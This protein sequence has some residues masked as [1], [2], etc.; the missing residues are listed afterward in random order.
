MFRAFNKKKTIE[1]EELKERDNTLSYGLKQYNKYIYDPNPMGHDTRQ[2]GLINQFTTH[3]YS[4]ITKLSKI[5]RDIINVLSTQD[6]DFNSFCFNAETTT[7]INTEGVIRNLNTCPAVFYF[8]KNENILHST[9]LFNVKEHDCVY[10]DSFC[11]NQIKRL[12]GG[13]DILEEFINIVRENGFKKIQLDAIITAVSFYEKLGFIVDNPSDT[14]DTIPMT[15]IIQ[16][17]GK[18]HK[19]KKKNKKI[20]KTF[21]KK[22]KKCRKYKIY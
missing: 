15:K 2:E 9:I 1:E 3:G 7:G 4:Y 16:Q 6:E 22:S 18:K 20:K 10:I 13:K 5:Y 21:R 8:I 14:R 17:G 19:T 12:K 11:V